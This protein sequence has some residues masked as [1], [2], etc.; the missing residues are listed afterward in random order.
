MYRYLLSTLVLGSLVVIASCDVL[1]EQI[2]SGVT[3]DAH[4]STPAGFE[5]AVNAAYV[6]LRQYYGSEQGGN[7]NALG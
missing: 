7:L 1:D 4:Y 6:Q 2:V 5:D 3:V